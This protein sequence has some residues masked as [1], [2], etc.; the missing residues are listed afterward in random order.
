MVAHDTIK[1]SCLPMSKYVPKNQGQA[2]I[3]NNTVTSARNR[4]WNTTNFLFKK[5]GKK[6][7]HRK[8]IAMANPRLVTE[9]AFT[10]ICEFFSPSLWSVYVSLRVGV[11]EVKV[12]K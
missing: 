3:K 12:E 10:C 7:K 4:E 5:K 9:R 1:F 6:K 11:P 8:K 2:R